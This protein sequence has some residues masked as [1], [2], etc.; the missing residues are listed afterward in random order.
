MP[1][2]LRGGFDL[3]GG[4]PTSRGRVEMEIPCAGKSQPQRSSRLGGGARFPCNKCKKLIQI[5]QSLPHFLTVGQLCTSCPTLTIHTRAQGHQ[6][7]N[8]SLHSLL[9]IRFEKLSKSV[10]SVI[11][12]EFNGDSEGASLGLSANGVAIMRGDPSPSKSVAVT[13]DSEYTASANQPPPPARQNTLTVVT[14][15]HSP[16]SRLPGAQ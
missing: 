8:V 2:G 11:R 1:F 10:S 7:P 3:W 13:E 5:N 14:A 15:R 16:S 9:Y 4:S 6:R 12:S